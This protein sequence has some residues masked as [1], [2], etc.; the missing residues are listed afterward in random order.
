LVTD[1]V[2]G[3]VI[4]PEPAD[5][6]TG[7]AGG[8]VT[9]CTTP[10]QRSAT[11][12]ARSPGRPRAVGR[13]DQILAAASRAIA[14]RGA[15]AVRFADV[16]AATD[17]AVAT[18]QHH[19]GARAN[20]LAEAFVHTDR[21]ELERLAD[22]ANEP[23]CWTRVTAL[24]DVAIG[25]ADDW[26]ER[27]L[28]WIEF[29][30][31]AAREPGL[32]GRSDGFGFVWRASL[33]AAIAEGVE[34]GR[35]RPRGTVDDAVSQIAAVMNGVMVPVILERDGADI[36]EARRLAVDATATILAAT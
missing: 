7:T 28:I 17:V 29:W 33:A 34:R 20:L 4:A 25:T 5:D 27:W 19:F 24:L 32:R 23:D 35:F 2:E 1:G 13:R 3:I 31:A 21:Q 10:L 6:R 9:S 14:D 11:A 16:A 22:L 8:T 15:D 30:R 36:G 18:I 12:A 26:R